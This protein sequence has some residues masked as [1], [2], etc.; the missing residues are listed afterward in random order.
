MSIEP[1]PA[2]RT[3]RSRSAQSGCCGSNLRNFVNN[4]YA[5]SAQPIGNPGCPEFAACTPSAERM[6]IVLTARSSVWGSIVVSVVIFSYTEFSD[7]RVVLR[8]RSASS[9][10]P[11]RTPTRRSVTHLDFDSRR[12]S[13]SC[14]TASSRSRN[15]LSRRSSGPSSGP[16]LECA[17]MRRYRARPREGHRPRFGEPSSP[18]RGAAVPLSRRRRHRGETSLSSIALASPGG[19]RSADAF[20]QALTL[21]R[22]PDSCERESPPRAIRER[23]ESK[24]PVGLVPSVSV[25]G[26]W[27]DT[28]SK[29]EILRT[30]RGKAQPK[31][32]LLAGC[33]LPPRTIFSRRSRSARC[34]PLWSQVYR[35][36]WVAIRPWLAMYSSSTGR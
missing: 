12:G 30:Q 5:K 6:R 32:R 16:R 10:F 28:S 35:S 4:T 15:G 36:A 21:R 1:C 3:N 23:I 17:V 20:D 34:L 22:N 24:E 2:E 33:S 27:R 25:P 26:F 11:L 18:I 13:P 8:A 19:N 9:T 31:T 14:F 29:V 7:W